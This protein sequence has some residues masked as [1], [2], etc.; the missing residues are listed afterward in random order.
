M[1]LFSDLNSPMFDIKINTVEEDLDH[2]KISVFINY[3][4]KKFYQR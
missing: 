3:Q 1:L 4:D 2:K